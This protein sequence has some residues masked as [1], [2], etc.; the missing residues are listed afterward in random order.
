M[1]DVFFLEIPNKGWPVIGMRLFHLHRKVK[2]RPL[3]PIFRWRPPRLA[4][5]IGYTFG[6]SKNRPAIASGCFIST[7]RWTYS[8]FLQL[9]PRRNPRLKHFAGYSFETSRKKHQPFSMTQPRKKAFPRLPVK[10]G[11]KRNSEHEEVSLGKATFLG[12][13]VN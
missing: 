9:S 6:T 11:E 8:L 4:H 13:V 3:S 1:I 12:R 10:K 7:I 5:F 2:I